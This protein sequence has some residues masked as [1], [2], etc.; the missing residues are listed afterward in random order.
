MGTVHIW[1]WRMTLWSQF[2][3]ST[4]SVSGHR[5]PVLRLVWQVPPP[6][7]L[8]R[9]ADCSILTV[10]CSSCHCIDL[11]SCSGSWREITFATCLQ[12]RAIIFILP[13]DKSGSKAYSRWEPGAVLGFLRRQ[14]QYQYDHSQNQE[15]NHEKTTFPNSAVGKNRSPSTHSHT[16]ILCR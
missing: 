10:W 11:T 12:L 16:H 5:T 9:Q 13:G 7:G 3:P 8:S 14:L 2:S 6:A 1:G 15:V 4:F